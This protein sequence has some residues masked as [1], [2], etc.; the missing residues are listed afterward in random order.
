[1]REPFFWLHKNHATT[2][3]WPSFHVQ[4][5]SWCFDPHGTFPGLLLAHAVERGAAFLKPQ[6]PQPTS[7]Y[8][9]CTTA[10]FYIGESQGH[11]DRRGPGGAFRSG[12]VCGRD[13][14]PRHVWC[15]NRFGKGELQVTHRQGCIQMRQ[16]VRDPPPLDYCRGNGNTMISP[17]RRSCGVPASSI[18][19]QVTPHDGPVSFLRR[20]EASKRNYLHQ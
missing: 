8:S 11:L 4:L 5:D 6:R 16:R 19:G 18:F 10:F 12:D 20:E 14:L 13:D 15:G 3:L 9:V 7:L 2:L 1:M 17:P